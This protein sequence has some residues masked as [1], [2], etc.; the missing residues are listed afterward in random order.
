MPY[1]YIVRCADGL[2]YTG[3]TTDLKQRIAAHNDGK[4]ARFTRGRR[5]VKL[6]YWERHNTRGE[7]QKRESIL[8][9]YKRDKKELLISSFVS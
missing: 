8:K 2:Y 4:A 7:A 1:T 3:W 5:P 9:H 6:I